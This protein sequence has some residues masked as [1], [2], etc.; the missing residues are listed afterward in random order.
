MSQ[1]THGLKLFQFGM[2]CGQVVSSVERGKSTSMAAADFAK[3]HMSQLNLA[4]KEK[5][6]LSTYI[7]KAIQ[8]AEELYNEAEL[9]KDERAK[10]ENPGFSLKEL[11]EN[12]GPQV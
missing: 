1:Y 5:Q 4:H 3:L 12:P 9:K 6:I 7:W 10:A 8:R 2:L 11:I